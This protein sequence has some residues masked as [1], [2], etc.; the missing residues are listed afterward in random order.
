MPAIQKIRKHGALLIGVIGAALF[1]FIAEEFFRSMETTSNA[2]KQQVAEI[3]GE[4]VN[5]QDFQQMVNDRLEACKINPQL[6]AKS[7]M[8]GQPMGEKTDDEIRDEVWN[9]FVQYQ[10]VKHEA[11]KL[12][13]IVTDAEVQK[14]LKE[15]NA[16]SLNNYLPLLN[17]RYDFTTLQNFLEMYK[18]NR[19]NAQGAEM[20]QLETIHHVWKYAESELRKELLMNKYFMLFQSTATSS[21][22]VVAKHLWNDANDST[23]IVVATLP[24]QAITEQVKVTDED[25]KKAYEENKEM[26][27][28]DRMSWPLA[29]DYRDVKYIDVQV[30]P[31]DKDKAALN[32]RMEKYY[33]DL[34]GG[35]VAPSRVVATS[36]SL[37]PF[38][39]N[40]V[41]ADFF[42]QYPDVYNAVTTLAVDSMT[43]PTPFVERDATTTMN[44]VKLL[45]KRQVA[46]SIQFQLLPI[47]AEDAEKG[48]TRCDSVL[49]AIGAGSTFDAVA[50]KLLAG[51]DS[52]AYAPQWVSAKDLNTFVPEGATALYN[53]AMGVTSFIY[54]DNYFVLNILNRKGSATVYSAAVVKCTLNFS[55]DT[56]NEAKNKLNI[57]LG[58]N[59]DL[60]SV[61]KNAKAAGY[62][63][64]TVY[65]LTPASQNI[66]ASPSLAGTEV[67]AK[68]KDAVRWVFDDAKEGQ[69]SRIYD[70]GDS[71]DHILVVGLDKVHTDGYLPIE[72]DLVKA[73]LT[74]IVTAQ[75][76]GELAAK[77][78]Q[79]VKSIAD[80]ESRGALKAEYAVTF[81]DRAMEPKVLGAIAALK[82]GA[83]SQ[84]IIG[85]KGAYVV[86]VV[87]R[88]K[89]TAKYN[90]RM[91]LQSAAGQTSGYIGNLFFDLAKKA[92]VA[93]RRYKF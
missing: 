51:Q 50:K 52:T 73:Q 17:G 38:N 62:L 35:E 37:I 23:K 44:I 3:Y 69:I 32:E 41:T 84:P 13:L 60:A 19:A 85:T 92:K 74:A 86:Q 18:K 75:K 49:K 2:S 31:S 59:K 26:F 11:D 56:Y 30:T 1:A 40:Y 24:F 36:S 57:F 53:N 89:S 33:K 28:R 9:E 16:R 83:V 42:Q 61:E 65:R 45:G 6:K 21:N 55:N 88:V 64:K 34:K 63:V 81:N 79:G 12:G 90:E 72:N 15:G 22:P 80:A 8:Y 93:D 25:L 87:K 82:E 5:V 47:V 7:G 58:K 4:T 78:L 76:K 48:K 39:E 20:E 54:N 14:A 10:L 67:V 68:S 66:E 71:N 70:C 91:A 43:H 46:D 27:S 77:K 29:C